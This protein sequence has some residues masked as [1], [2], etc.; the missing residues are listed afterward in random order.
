MYLLS[1]LKSRLDSSLFVASVFLCVA[2]LALGIC[3]RG[4]RGLWTGLTVGLFVAL[5]VGLG[6]GLGLRTEVSEVSDMVLWYSQ[7][8]LPFKPLTLLKNDVSLLTQLYADIHI[9]YD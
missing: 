2:K 5:L 7:A 1:D 3:R 4:Q 6:V 8:F 9:S